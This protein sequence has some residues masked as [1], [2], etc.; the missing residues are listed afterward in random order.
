VRQWSNGQ[1]RPT[2]DCADCSVRSQSAKLEHTELSGVPPDCPVPQEDR[3]LQLSTTP[4]PNVRLTWHTPDSE[5]CSVWC[6]HRQQ[7]QPMARKWLEAINTPNHLHSS[8]PSLPTFSINTR[9]KSYTIRHNQSIK[10]S[11][12]SKIKSI[13]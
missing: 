11:Q 6:A 7:S 12:S 3:R 4:N 10:S 13:T 8:H 9:A 1:L 5:Q 2:V